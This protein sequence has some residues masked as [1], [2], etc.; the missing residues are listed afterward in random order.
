M[1]FPRKSLPSY[2]ERKLTFKLV[3]DI[4]VPRLS[5][6]GT[7]L[8]IL[9][10][11]AP[12]HL[13]HRE[14][15][16]ATWAN[17][18]SLQSRR[19]PFSSVDDWKIVFMLG[20]ADANTNAVVEQEASV[21][22]DIL[23]GE[24]QDSYKNLVIKTIM[25]LS[26]ASRLN[27]THVLKAD[28]DVYIHI[29]RLIT[30]LR[31]PSLPA[32][33]YAGRVYPKVPVLRQTT[34]KY[35]L[36]RESYPASYYPP[37][38][39]G[40]FYVLSQSILPALVNLTSFVKPILMEDAY[41]GMLTQTLGISLVDRSANFMVLSPESRVLLLDDCYFTSNIGLGHGISPSGLHAVHSRHLSIE[42]LNLEKQYLICIRYKLVFITKLLCLVSIVVIALYFCARQLRASLRACML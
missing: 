5:F 4:A 6:N 7:Y 17:R 10:T 37:Y 8:L 1:F 32:G 26:W 29:P 19:Q 28:D 42:S 2:K 14:A 34:S 15:I 11:S 39:A 23:L 20:K 27:C 33:L 13:Q 40:P 9:V 30:W 36:D 18:T 31:Q 41:I 35:F 3:T 24:F 22:N 25:G 21:F 16:R 38:C 12:S